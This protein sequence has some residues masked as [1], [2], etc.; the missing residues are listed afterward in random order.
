MKPIH[1]LTVAASVFSLMGC[2]NMGS[3][4]TPAAAARIEANAQMELCQNMTEKNDAVFQYPAV[5]SETPLEAVKQANEEAAE[6]VREVEKSADNLS[7]PGILEVGA[8]FRSLQ[9]SVNEI[10][11]GRATV[12]EDSEKIEMEAR[13]LKSAWNNLYRNLECGA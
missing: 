1:A 2:A 5:Y 11:G 12:G 4:S 13:N 10:P 9:N 8:A 7:N 3:R 6:A